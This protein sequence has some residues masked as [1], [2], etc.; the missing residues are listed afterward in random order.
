MELP[1][2][3]E[4]YSDLFNNQINTTTTIQLTKNSVH[5]FGLKTAPIQALYRFNMDNTGVLTVTCIAT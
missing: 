2:D 3:C 5:A 1:S 4:I